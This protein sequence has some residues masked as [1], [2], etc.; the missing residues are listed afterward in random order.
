[1]VD[2][3]QPKKLVITIGGLH[4]TGKTTYAK[5]LAEKF[6][7][8]HVSAGEIFRQLAKEKGLTLQ[9]LTSLAKKDRKIDELIDSRIREAAKKEDRV[10][11]D[12]LLSAWMAGE[13][14]DIKIYLFTSD[15]VRFKRIASREKIPYEEA[16]KL[17]LE[18]EKAEKERYKKF[19]GLDLDDLTVYDIVFNTDLLP[20]NSNIKVLTDVI[21]EYMKAKSGE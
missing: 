15:E 6:G 8:K 5:A 20:L 19:Y 13:R 18:R 16:K 7:L 10:I 11:I 12:G 14:A 4:G 9:E 3:Q 17:T 21:N 2:K 1:M